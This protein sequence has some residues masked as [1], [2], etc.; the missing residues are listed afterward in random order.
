MNNML[1]LELIA[2]FNIGMYICGFV[3]FFMIMTYL[4]LKIKY[5]KKINEALH[6]LEKKNIKIED[7]VLSLI[8]KK[9][10]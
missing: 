7:I 4:D 3:L 6:N 2:L 1:G 8:D 10:E 5:Q 9:E